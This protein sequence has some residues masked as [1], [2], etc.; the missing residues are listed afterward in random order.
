MPKKFILRMVNADVRPQ[1]N[2]LLPSECQAKL[3]EFIRD[4]PHSAELLEKLNFSNNA[5]TE[6][7]V[8]FEITHDEAF[9]RTDTA[10]GV[11]G[12]DAFYPFILRAEYRPSIVIGHLLQ[13]AEV[14][15]LTLPR[16]PELRKVIVERAASALAYAV[17][18]ASSIAIEAVVDRAFIQL[19]WRNTAKA[20]SRAMKK[21][22]PLLD[23]L[24][25]ARKQAGRGRPG[26]YSREMIE[27]FN[28][29]CETVRDDLKRRRQRHG[30]EFFVPLAVEQW[31]EES[32]DELTDENGYYLRRLA[33]RGV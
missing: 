23:K 16:D 8:S 2:K 6:R 1:R 15:G 11:Y 14:E 18:E 21:F 24:F 4:A 20:R 31:N 33:Q 9:W 19:S 28:R 3:A 10:Q 12:S 17:Y 29:L 27:G 7:G 22:I 13:R 5:S 32:G 30:R 25:S 26:E